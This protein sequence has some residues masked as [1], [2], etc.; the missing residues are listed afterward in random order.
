M[1][2]IQIKK[3]L[4]FI[5]KFFCRTLQ[6]LLV[7]TIIYFSSPTANAQCCS[8]NFYGNELV[9][10]G[11]FSAGNTG[12]TTAYTFSAAAFTGSYGITTDAGIANP[13][14][15][16]NCHDRT[17]GSGN[18]MWVDLASF[19]NTNI[20]TQTI[21]GILPNTNYLFSCWICNL[22][23][24][25]PATL[26]LSVNGNLVGDSLT[27]PATSCNWTK[28][29]F[30]WYS[31]NST[32]ASLSITNQSQHANGNDIGLDDISFLKCNPSTYSFSTAAICQGGSYL[33][34]GGTFATTSGVYLDTLQSIQGCDSVIT[35]TLSVDTVQNHL[36]NAAIC[37]GNTYL[38]PNGTN[39]S[40]P[41]I[42]SDTLQTAAGC[43]SIITVNLTYLPQIE[44][45]FAVT[46]VTC[47]GAADGTITLFATN[48]TPPYTYQVRFVSINTT[49]VFTD[50]DTG[51]YT[52]I[53]ID[54]LGCKALGHATITEPAPIT[55]SVHPD[56]A[57]IEAG[58][59]IQLVATCTNCANA[60]YQWTPPDFLSCDT[61]FNPVA[62]PDHDIIY[63]VSVTVTSN[64]KT[65]SEDTVTYIHVNPHFFLP[66]SFTPNND[67]KNDV[68]E[69]LGDNKENATDFEIKIYN[70]WGQR[71]FESNDTNFQW[72]GTYNNK[73][74][75]TGIYQYIIKYYRVT[76]DRHPIS[77]NGHIV[78]LN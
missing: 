49:G 65:C 36:T 54:D 45:S 16:S 46:P 26:Q 56:I 17:S 30:I 7:N 18:L 8:C 28:L 24:G 40:V 57:Y 52:Y 60:T 2:F 32:T 67:G 13:G 38:L 55:I 14:V 77:M 72:N 71:V 15:W 25:D 58:E 47:H 44:D 29:C 19:T 12:F 50:L 63:Q 20:W 11:D 39:V 33:L 27:A 41:G 64:G 6:L 34:P 73:K 42:Y 37:V 74:L 69:L 70:R 5:Y 1:S 4:S 59:A 51:T 62:A 48:S 68:L 61:C 43:D 9:T 53:I 78:I 3:I 21:N 75:A 31:G 23:S 66:N 35:T 22:Q 10:N 76:D